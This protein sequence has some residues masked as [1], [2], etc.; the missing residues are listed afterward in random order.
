MKTD[1][2]FTYFTNTIEGISLPEKFTFPFYYEPHPLC[3]LAAKELQQY[4]ETQTEWEC[5]F[6][7]TKG[8]EDTYM[9]KMF[10]ILVVQ[11]KNN[12]IGYLSAF[13]GK[14]AG[15]NHLERFVP[16]V[17][18][19]LSGKSFYLEE[20]EVLNSINR[21]IEAFETSGELKEL[22]ELKENESKLANAA[23]AE[24]K[25]RLKAEKEDRKK[26]RINSNE[27][28]STEDYEKL[29]QE[30]VK[31]SLKGKHELKVLKEYWKSRLQ[32]V[33]EQL[34]MLE[35]SLRELKAERM[36]KS[37]ALQQK[38][39]EQYRFL[40]ANGAEKGLVEIFKE[41]IDQRPPAA[42][43]ECAAPKLL[44]Y[45]YL[46]EMKP[47]A[48]AEF[49]WGQSPKAEV[50]KH[51]SFYPAC[52]GKCEPILGHMLEG[53]VVDP[54][55]MLEESQEGKDISV[56][57]EDDSFAVIIKPNE[58]LSV[59]GKNIRN[60]VYQ[61]MKLKYPEATGPLIVHRLDMAT[62][63]LMLIAKTEKS[64]KRLQKQF[65]KRKVQKRYVAILDG[66]VKDNEGVI[67]LPL[68]VDLED[69]PRQLVCHEHGKAARTIWKVVD[70]KNNITRIH[71]FPVTGRTHQLR[72]HAAHQ[73][74]LNTPIVGDDLYGTKADRLYLHAE[75]ITFYHP[76]TNEVMTIEAKA[77]F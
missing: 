73:L 8:L 13:S 7:N 58:F 5:D 75:S 64:Y 57:Y 49:W 55:P 37:A 69:R 41:A 2:Y 54:N 19:M 67:N 45:A 10:G 70:R 31:E 28:L 63:G 17:F 21:K 20:M 11:N 14:L 18:D 44:Q 15:S 53:I 77:D 39:F 12:E 1:R 16:P 26:K 4:I 62:S 38:L 32:Q 43:G 9:G 24:K 56:I 22:K 30:L 47:I 40:N 35:N 36:K 3:E 25:S 6:H 51:G 60:S 27:T 48:M 46:H 59:P 29:E 61:Q 33:E 66:V 34:T 72:V 23:L 42:A 68:R 74:G 52:R 71:F 50:R 76:D 65:I